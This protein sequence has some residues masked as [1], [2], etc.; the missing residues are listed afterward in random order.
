MEGVWCTSAHPPDELASLQTSGRSTEALGVVVAVEPCQ[1]VIGPP[2]NVEQLILR[3]HTRRTP[4]MQGQGSHL[5]RSQRCV[6]SP[7]GRPPS[8]RTTLASSA[9]ETVRRA[10]LHAGPDR[11]LDSHRGAAARERKGALAV[12]RAL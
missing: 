6:A 7:R 12:A 9:D 3:G 1:R 2:P 4:G 5:H 11:P 8:R 10:F